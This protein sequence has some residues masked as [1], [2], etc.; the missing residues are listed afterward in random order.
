MKDGD[1]APHNPMLREDGIEALMQRVAL[2]K[3]SRG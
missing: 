1:T 2:R 3:S